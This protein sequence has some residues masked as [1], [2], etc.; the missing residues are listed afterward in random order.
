[1][2][3]PAKGRWHDAHFVRSSSMWEVDKCGQ[4]RSRAIIG[5]RVSGR[6]RRTLALLQC[7]P[8]GDLA[9]ALKRKLATADCFDLNQC[10]DSQN[11]SV[12]CAMQKLPD[13]NPFL[14]QL[15]RQFFE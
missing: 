6:S 15:V 14:T 9:H 1:M 10:L 4:R 13:P 7:F 8:V 2:A 3:T 12:L 5:S 11:S